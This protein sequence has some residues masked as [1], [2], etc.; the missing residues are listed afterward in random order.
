MVTALIGLVTMVAVKLLDERTRKVQ[1]DAHALRIRCDDLETKLQMSQHVVSQ[2]SLELSRCEAM[3][4]ELHSRYRFVL[5]ELLVCY[6]TELKIKSDRP[7]AR[8]S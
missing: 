1:S 8:D 4:D 3:I 2:M 7:P 6:T 5:D